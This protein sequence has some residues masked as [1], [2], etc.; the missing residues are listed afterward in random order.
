MGAPL[1]IVFA[2]MNILEAGLIVGAVSRHTRTSDILS[3][4]MLTNRT[5]KIDSHVLEVSGEAGA[6]AD[7]EA[8]KAIDVRTHP[9]GTVVD[10]LPRCKDYRY[11]S[12]CHAQ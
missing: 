5:G 11:E 1:I 3:D 7:C 12:L 4:K 2:S 8:V 9:K 10:D 6:R